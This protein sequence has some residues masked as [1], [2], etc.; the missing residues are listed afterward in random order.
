M[1][2][3]DRVLKDDL[4]EELDEFIWQIGGHEGLHSHGDILGVLH[5][6]PILVATV[7]AS[8]IHSLQGWGSLGAAG[9]GYKKVITYGI[10]FIHK[11]PTEQTMDT[12]LC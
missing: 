11:L 8:F 5:N 9:N 12:S 10:L 4:L 3:E 6:T 1:V 7:N 2:G